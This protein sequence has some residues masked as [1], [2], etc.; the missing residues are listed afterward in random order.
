MD[1]IDS[2][3]AATRNWR[4]SPVD[5]PAIPVRMVRVGE[6]P[7]RPV[8]A[9]GGDM[10]DATRLVPEVGP[11]PQLHLV[12]LAHHLPPGFRGVIARLELDGAALLA[13]VKLALDGGAGLSSPFPFPLPPGRVAGTRGVAVATIPEPRPEHPR[14]EVHEDGPDGVCLRGGT[15]GFNCD[16]VPDASLAKV[17]DR[18]WPIEMLPLSDLQ[19]TLNVNVIGTFNCLKEEMKKMKRGGSIANCG[20]QGQ[21]RFG[22]HE[23]VRHIEE[24]RSRSVP[25]R[26]LR[27]RAQGDQGQ[28]AMPIIKRYAK[29]EEIA[30]SIAF[31]IGDESKFIAKQEYVDSG[32]LGSD[33]VD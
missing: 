16:D 24:R 8:V 18:I 31:L 12:V 29:P 17:N 23:R 30:A 4:I 5:S 27:R 25:S 9:F 7:P 20:S 26:R 21:T 2:H 14:Q 22:A 13:A 33:Y 6:R 1:D 3:K 15:R 11:C 10:H 28:P 32:R 19:E